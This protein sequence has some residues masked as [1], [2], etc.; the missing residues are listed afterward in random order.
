MADRLALQIKQ[1]VQNMVQP[2][3]MGIVMVGE[4]PVTQ[5]YVERKRHFAQQAGITFVEKYL[6]HDITQE[7]LEQEIADFAEQ[8]N[9]LV[10]QLPLPQHVDRDT[11]LMLI[12]VDKDVDVLRPDGTTEGIMGPVAGAVSDILR[13]N[14][15]DVSG[16]DCVVIGRGNLVGKPVAAMLER[17]GG[18]VTIL[19]KKTSKEEY[20]EAIADADLIVSGVGS[21]NMITPDMIKDGVVLIDAGTSSDNGKLEGDI[22]PDCADHAVLFSPTPGGVGPMTVAKLFENLITLRTFAD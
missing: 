18:V 10:V 22:H 21:P 14:N 19:D 3:I 2:P 20:T 12:P 11:I 8:V 16:R 9:G 6:P 13:H 7:R 15:V 5:S 17:R 4:N 1:S